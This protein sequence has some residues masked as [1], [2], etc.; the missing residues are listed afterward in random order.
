MNPRVLSIGHATFDTFLKIDPHDARLECTVDNSNCKICFDFGSKVP[1]ESVHYG[2]GG[3]AANVAVGLSRLGL[4]SYIFTVVGNDMR[5]MEIVSSF[6]RNKINCSFLKIDS[7]PTN[8]SSIISYQNDRTIFSYHHE[9]DYSFEDKEA[10]HE[11][12]FVG[13]VGVDVSKLYDEISKMKVDSPG[14]KVFYNPGKRE[15]KSARDIL[16]EFLAYVDYLVVNVEEACS[17]LDPTLSRDS[18]EINDL[19]R[20]LREKGPE[21]IIITDGEGGSYAYDG[22]KFLFMPAKKVDV[23]EKTGAGD[24]FTSGFI[25]GISSGLDIFR[26][27]EW[28]I[29]NSASTIQKY[30]AQHGLL[31]KNSLLELS[32][33]KK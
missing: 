17:I 4:E 22:Y 16:H 1:V 11:Y 5:G 32:G 28:G 10:F 21:N 26:A 18:I 6:K 23:V 13:S 2:V 15:I 29:I 7:N 3:S 25:G 20:L 33:K 8:Q 12:V 9:R 31:D 24:A 30:G 19:S 14:K 27:A